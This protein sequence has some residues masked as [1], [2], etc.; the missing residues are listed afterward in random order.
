VA[1]YRPTDLGAGPGH[2][3]NLPMRGNHHR[4]ISGKDMGYL[5]VIGVH[6]SL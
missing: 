2:T 5:E 4:L 1:S 3:R 6:P